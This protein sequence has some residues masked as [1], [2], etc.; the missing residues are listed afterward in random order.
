VHALKMDLDRQRKWR[1]QRKSTGT[2]LIDRLAKALRQITLAALG[3]FGVGA[4]AGW[5]RAPLPERLVYGS[6][7]VGSLTFVFAGLGY[8]VANAWSNRLVGRRWLS[9]WSSW[10]GKGTAKLVGLG[11]NPKP[12]P[13]ALERPRAALLPDS[14]GAAP[15]AHDEIEQVREL[16]ETSMVRIASLLEDSKATRVREE[17]QPT[18]QEAETEDT[19]GRQLVLMEALRERLLA[20]DATAADWDSLSV[21]LDAARE[22]CDAAQAVMEGQKE[23]E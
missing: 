20:V 8:L 6:M 11:L 3:L 14:S 4:L 22:V 23:V 1:K 9:F 2:R 5:L 17:R 7:I 13:A 18:L 21:D 15:N 10:L 16:T 19:L 12:L